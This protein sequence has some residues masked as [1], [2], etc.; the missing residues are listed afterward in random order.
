MKRR[1]V[2]R[3]G[4]TLA[5]L[6]DLVDALP[7]DAV[8]AAVEEQRLLGKEDSDSDVID[9]D[10][11]TNKTEGFGIAVSRRRDGGALTGIDHATEGVRKAYSSTPGV[12]KRRERVVKQERMVFERT[13][14]AIGRVPG[15]AGVPAQPT[16]TTAAVAATTTTNKNKKGWQDNK[17]GAEMSART[18]NQWELLRS[19]ITMMKSA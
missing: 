1:Q 4:N 7:A 5:R 6:D 10:H 19:A 16:T 2:R 11:T 18:T 13:L 3:D 12:L 17:G 15:D 14:A 9:G 8:A